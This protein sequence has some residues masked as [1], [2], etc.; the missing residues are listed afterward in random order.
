MWYHTHHDVAVA[1]Y[2]HRSRTK[3]EGEGARVRRTETHEV[4]TARSLVGRSFESI[5]FGCVNHVQRRA[6]RYPTRVLVVFVV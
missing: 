4:R 2:A 5:Q 6:V 1:E 3:K